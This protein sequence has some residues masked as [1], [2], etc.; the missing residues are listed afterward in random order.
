MKWIGSPNYD[1]NR[2][3]IDRVVIHWFGVGNQAGADATFQKK[4]GTSAHYSV[5]DTTIHQYVKEEHVAYHAG[6]YAMNQRSIGV[7]H[8]ATPD[9]PA[10]EAT[11]QTAG[12]LLGEIC[13][14]HN[15]PLD[16]EHIIKHS[17]VPRA[18]QC[19]GTID[20]DKLIAIAK[21]GDMAD[22]IESLK[23]QLAE[24]EKN[25]KSLQEQVDGW[26]RDSQNGTWVSS[27]DHIKAQELAYNK[28]FEAGKISA[29]VAEVDMSK[30]QVNGLTVST[31]SGDKTTSL[32]Y[33]LK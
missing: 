14:R 5:E 28:G 3:T 24:S 9:R 33:K 17:E 19:C 18:T 4:G 29:P 22:T 26:V 20:I 32:N 23:A 15:I 6:N 30:W 25:K 21:G 1:T 11:Y 31:V 7:E 16:R 12:K 10:T 2:K 13:G 8:S 27:A